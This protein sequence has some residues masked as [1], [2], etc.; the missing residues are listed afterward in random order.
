[1]VMRLPWVKELPRSWTAAMR[2]TAV[3]IPVNI[4]LFSQGMGRP[5][6]PG[7]ENRGSEAVTS[8][9]LGPQAQVR[10]DA[11]AVQEFEFHRFVEC[12]Q[13]PDVHH[14]PPG[15]QQ[16]GGQVDQELVHQA[17]AHQ[18]AVEL[19]AGLDMHLVDLATA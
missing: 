13:R 19:V 17:L 5:A 4:P 14:A 7:S 1:M 18:R 12:G 16:L 6:A 15:T 11:G 3:M 2:P 10:A 9:D 8:P